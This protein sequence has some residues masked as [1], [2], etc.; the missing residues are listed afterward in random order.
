MKLRYIDTRGFTMN[1]RAT[2][3]RFVKL[4]T[5]EVY[6][7]TDA[8]AKYLLGQKNGPRPMWEIVRE[9]THPRVRAAVEG[10]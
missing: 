1:F 10:A 8:E 9:S 5:G 4:K 6:E 3:G 2:R 7:C